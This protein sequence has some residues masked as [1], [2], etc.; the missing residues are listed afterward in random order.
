MTSNVVL[1]KKNLV[2]FLATLYYD[3]NVQ[4]LHLYV[5]QLTEHYSRTLFPQKIT[6]ALSRK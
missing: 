5:W 6:F 4:V 3:D 1:I 2:G